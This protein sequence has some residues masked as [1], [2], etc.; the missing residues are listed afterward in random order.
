M[1]SRGGSGAESTVAALVPLHGS[2]RRKM[3]S[4]RWGWNHVHPTERRLF[5][6][7]Q[8]RWTVDKLGRVLTLPRCLFSCRKGVGEA[9]APL[10]FKTTAQCAS[11]SSLS[12]TASESRVP[13]WCWRLAPPTVRGAEP[14]PLCVARILSARLVRR[15]R[16]QR[17][18]ALSA[19]PL[20]TWPSARRQC[21]GR[22]AH[23]RASITYLVEASMAL[24]LLLRVPNERPMS[25]KSTRLLRIERARAVS[26]AVYLSWRRVR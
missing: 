21:S 22:A 3:L 17:L 20:R 7:H 11:T 1:T 16:A 15:D 10:V 13:R 9:C 8:P 2:V 26:R 25:T 4:K 23:A 5:G 12:L 24:E 19:R 18:C 6:E 14:P